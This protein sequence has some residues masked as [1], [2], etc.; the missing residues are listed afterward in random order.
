MYHCFPLF[1][2]EQ[3]IRIPYE[4]PDLE[5]I[6]VRENI[7]DYTFEDFKINNYN[8]HNEIRMRMRA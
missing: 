4:P 5:I 2:Q 8:H 3:I 7:E 1:L 6:N